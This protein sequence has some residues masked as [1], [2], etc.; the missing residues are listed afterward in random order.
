MSQSS[1]EASSQRHV[2]RNRVSFLEQKIP[3]YASIIGILGILIIWE[4]ICR[5]EL[6]SPLFLPAPTAILSAG[7]DMAVSGEMH[8]DI[9]AS[10]YRIIA[11]YLIGAVCG[12]V[13]G[14]ILGFSRWVD[15]MLTPVVYSLYPIPK[16]ALLP[17]F[18]LWLG[19]GETPKI[20]MIALGVFFPVVINTFSGVK[21][22]DPILIKA[23]V[24]FGSSHF[25]VIRK[26]ILP[27]SLPMIFA[28]LKLAMGSALLLL[29]PAEMIAAQQG[30]GSM[31]QHYGNL[32]LATKLMVGVVILSLM[33]LVFNRTLQW[34]ERKLLPWK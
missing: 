7:W 5:M 28:G 30:V 3:A 8:P 34:I 6:V 1:R 32:M 33:G 4:A 29:V 24:T 20:T 17:L 27:G 14:L 19:I 25:N 23:A 22:V 21:N 9:L 26:V 11:G 12:I 31:V 2:I 13:F 15:A 18:V 10:L 16:I